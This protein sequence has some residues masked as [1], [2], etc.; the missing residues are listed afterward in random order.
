MRHELESWSMPAKT[1]VRVPYTALATELRPD[2]VLSWPNKNYITWAKE[3]GYDSLEFHALRRVVNDILRMPEAEL[4]TKTEIKSGH[5]IFNPY[6]TI[7]SVLLRKKDPLRPGERLAFYNLF[8][9]ENEQAQ[10]A[11]H[12]LE[13]VF[14]GNFPVVTYPYE[15]GGT[16][17]FGEYDTPL[18]QTHPSVFNDKSRAE[19]FIK[20]VKNGE[21]A[22][23]VWDTYHALEATKTGE[24]PLA[25]WKRA[26]STLLDAG[27]VKEVHVQAG[28]IHHNDPSVPSLE[29]LQGMTGPNPKYNSELGQ[30]IK[31]VKEA[32]LTIAFVVEIAI[33]SLVKAGLVKQTSLIFGLNEVKEVH[34]ELI[35][36]IKR[37]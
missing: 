32:N 1:E 36:Y 21:Y 34:Q 11:L 6:A 19:D 13:K 20:R 31:M 25:D 23:V 33:T 15:P 7:Q 37:V 3:T 24:R 2:I 5:V 35:D 10:R 27:V 26:L 18:L 8:L 17:P 16:K 14:R 29:W 28:R 30:M 9:A 12:K 22:G 4:K